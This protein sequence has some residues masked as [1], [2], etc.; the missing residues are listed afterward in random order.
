MKKYLILILLISFTS[1]YCQ[2]KELKTASKEL[3]KGNFEKANISLDAAEDLITSMS[4][5]QKGDFYLLKSKFYYRNGKFSSEDLDKSIENFLKVSSVSDPKAKEFHYFELLNQL[6]TQS[7]NY[8]NN[9]QFSDASNSIYKAYE[10]SNDPYYLYVSASWSVQAK[11]YEKSLLMYE[12]LKSLKYTGIEEQFFATNKSTNVEEQFNNKIMRDASVKSKTHNNPVDKKTKSKYPE[13]IKNIALIYNQ[14]GET[15]KA[16]NAINEAR[17]ENPNDLDLI[18]NEAN[19]YFQMGNMEKFKSLLEDATKLD[20]DNAELQYNLGYLS[21]EIKDYKT[22]TAYYERAIEI[23]P[24]YVDAY[25]NL[26]VMI[27]TPEVEINNEMNELIS[28]NRSSCYDRYDELKLE[29]K[30]LYSKAI[31]YIEKALQIDSSNIQVLN[32]MSQMLSALDRVDEAK[33]YRE[34]AKN[35]EN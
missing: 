21:A 10:I 18:I 24:D 22:A 15:D 19:V 31:P 26:A 11:D 29:K 5:K 35:L 33:K 20:P 13:I 23:N 3:S 16:L 34:R 27:L 6:T 32:K 1:I 17:L 4:E 8:F 2:K 30:K 12:K 7:N 14:M 25:I 9:Q 28:C